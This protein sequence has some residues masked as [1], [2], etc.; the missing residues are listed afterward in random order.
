[1]AGTNKPSLR[2]HQQRS[3]ALKEVLA[4]LIEKRPGG[5]GAA[6]NAYVVG[7]PHSSATLAPVDE[8]VV[9]TV[10]L[11]QARCFNRFLPCDRC[12]R[13]IRFKSFPRRRIQFHNLYPRPIRPKRQPEPSQAVLGDAGINRIKTVARAGPNH[14][15][16][17]S[18]PIA[19]IAGIERLA[20]RQSDGGSL[21]AP[22]R[23]RIVKQV[24]IFEMNNIR[25]PKHASKSRN[26]VGSPSR[27]I[28]ENDWPGLP[29]DKIGR[30]TGDDSTASGKDP[31]LASV[32]YN[33]RRIMSR[34]IAFKSQ[35]CR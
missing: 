27:Q 17:I 30:I 10:M 1:M 31:V 20:R 25:R 35:R 5:R 9:I 23:N 14:N 2:L 13:R 19:W 8:E 4:R 22:G 16:A 28:C 15:S 3:A 12:D 6:A 21:R 18:P 11:I 32:L 33:R 34:E 26:G 29:R 24:A 7:A